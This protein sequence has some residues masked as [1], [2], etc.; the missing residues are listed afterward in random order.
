MGGNLLVVRSFRHSAGFDVLGSP[1]FGRVICF[2]TNLIS[3][4]IRRPIGL[5]GRAFANGPGVQSPVESYQ[6]LENGT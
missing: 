6:K 3:L 4:H 1:R 2:C 5:I